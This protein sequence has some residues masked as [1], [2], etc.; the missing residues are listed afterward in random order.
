VRLS[1]LLDRRVVDDSDHDLGRVRDVRLVQD[2]PLVGGFGA[3]FRVEGLIVGPRLAGTR[4]GYGRTG[5]KG[6]WLLE[7]P[8]RA[9]HRRVRFVPWVRVRDVGAD[10]LRISGSAEDLQEPE[11]L[12]S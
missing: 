1:E 8:L 3:A 12:R 2:G 10:V 7:A 5:M 6:P 9:L 4:L 11:P